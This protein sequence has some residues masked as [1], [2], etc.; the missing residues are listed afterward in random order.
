MAVAGMALC[1]CEY[2]S[3]LCCVYTGKLAIST[4]MHMS[5]L[6]VN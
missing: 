4:S 2:I 3:N 1:T 5:V 6:S